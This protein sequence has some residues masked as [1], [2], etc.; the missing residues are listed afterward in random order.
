MSKKIMFNE[1][2]K[3]LFLHIPKT[4]GTSINTAVMS[5][6]GRS[7]KNRRHYNIRRHGLTKKDCDE[8]NIFAVLRNPFTRIAS[9]Y[10]HFMVGP[11]IFPAYRCNKKSY[12]FYK[13]LLNIKKYFDGV[14][15]PRPPALSRAYRVENECEKDIRARILLEIN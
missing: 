2:E 10:N 11:E 8:Y 7:T 15:K 9:T 6:L 13:Y 5:E 1:K 14:L 3:F 4:G 12:T